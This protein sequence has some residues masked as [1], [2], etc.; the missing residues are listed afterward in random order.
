MYRPLIV[1]LK[2]APGAEMPPD[3]GAITDF[4]DRSTNFKRKG[5]CYQS[6]IAK[7]R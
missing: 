6:Q 5:L 2:N 7:Y 4:E 3:Y 1:V